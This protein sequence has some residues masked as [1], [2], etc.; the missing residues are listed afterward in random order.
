MPFTYNSIYFYVFLFFYWTSHFCDPSFRVLRDIFKKGEYEMKKYLLSGLAI[1]GLMMAAAHA[2]AMDFSKPYVLGEAGYSFGTSDT[3]DAGILGVGVGYHLNQYLRTDLTVG[4]RGWSDV[5]MKTTSGK[6]KADLWSVPVLAN[7]Y[8]TM[9]INQMF[10][11]YGMG[12][13]GMAWNKTDS[14]PDAKGATKT[15]FAWTAGVGIDYM[16]NECMSL[17]LGYRYTDLGQ[18]R[19]KA[20]DGYTGKS[21][22]DVR[23]NDV[24]LTARYYF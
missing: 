9:P 4:Y 6:K 10:S 12:G 3:G 11:V 16:V 23:S 19:V 2:Q 8:A 22:Q 5:D 1:A 13:I 24:K 15:N 7:I 14:L 17:D 20:R 18:A 21:K